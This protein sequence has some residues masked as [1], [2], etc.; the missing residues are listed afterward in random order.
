[1]HLLYLY[2]T[3]T[4]THICTFV[5][6]EIRVHLYSYLFHSLIHNFFLI[7]ICVRILLFYSIV[8]DI[9]LLISLISFVKHIARKIF[10]AFLIYLTWLLLN[11]DRLFLFPFS[12]RQRGSEIFVI[13]YFVLLE[14]F[15]CDLVVKMHFRR[16]ALSR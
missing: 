13:F 15:A 12:N 3:C 4:C 1:M 5:P 2:C 6:I 8:V 11:D 16:P 7:S 14:E 10:C 9:F